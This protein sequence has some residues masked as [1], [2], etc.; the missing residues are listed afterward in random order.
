MKAYVTSIGE[1]TTELC[2]WSLER[3]G[4]EV[5]IVQDDSSLGSKLKMIYESIDD[6]FVRV[7]ADVVV[8]KT[9]TPDYIEQ[10]FVLDSRSR[11]RMHLKDIW[12]VQFMCYGW[13]TQNLIYGGVQF[14]KKEALPML[15]NNVDT[16]INDDR[17]ETM[18]SRIPEFY[19]PR[20]FESVEDCVGIHGYAADD[21]DRVIAQKKKRGYFQDY[22]FELAERLDQL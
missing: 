21:I 11:D 1:N 17:P 2:K 22:D 14:I 19:K 13:F 18:L 3:N 5:V 20:R 10:L 6:D 16:F 12:W 7:D 9:I 15:R 8:N 4:F